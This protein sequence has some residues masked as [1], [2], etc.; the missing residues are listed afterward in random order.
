MAADPY[1]GEVSKELLHRALRHARRKRIQF[2]RSIVTRKMADQQAACASLIEDSIE[3]QVKSLEVPATEQRDR[4]ASL[5]KRPKLYNSD[6]EKQQ[7]K[8]R[9]TV[10]HAAA[11]LRD[12]TVRASGFS[13]R[14]GGHFVVKS[15]S[16]EYKVLAA[17]AAAGAGVVAPLA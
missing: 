2:A 12:W 6:E 17:F 1:A 13:R 4:Q 10:E 15:N 8:A 7:A 5:R 3:S 14:N 11:V 16:D 9:R